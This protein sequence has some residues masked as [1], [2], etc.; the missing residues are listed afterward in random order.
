M[1][2]A[3]DDEGGIPSPPMSIP[4]VAAATVPAAATIL[5]AKSVA[6]V[7]KAMAVERAAMVAAA[8]VAPVVAVAA[9]GDK[10]VQTPPTMSGMP[11]S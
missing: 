5:T 10:P 2:P 1:N 8:V 7:D 3:P 9:V 6:A 11:T 4:T